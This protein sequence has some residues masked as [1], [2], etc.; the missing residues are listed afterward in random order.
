MP[1][2]DWVNFSNLSDLASIIGFFLTVYVS[3]GVRKIEKEFLFRARLP[4]LLKQ[5]QS[6]AT[7]LST[8]L[9]NFPNSENEVIEELSIAKVNINSLYRKSSGEIKIS[10]KKLEIE[11]EKFLN[12]KSND[13]SKK[14]IRKIYLAMNMVIQE[15]TNLREDEKWRQGNG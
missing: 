11:I 10:L 8:H 1:M 2:P 15:I 12:E 3:R 14:D 4:S 7:T 5:L 6:H 13:N 9:Q